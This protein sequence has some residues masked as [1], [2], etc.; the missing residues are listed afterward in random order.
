M[1]LLASTMIAT[2]QL[3]PFVEEYISKMLK[4]AKK[5]W[6]KCQFHITNAFFEKTKKYCQAKIEKHRFMLQTTSTE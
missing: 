6:T 3:T 1:T 2:I 4:R 5:S